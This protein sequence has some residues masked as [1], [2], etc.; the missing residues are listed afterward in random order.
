MLFF[1][2]QFALLGISDFK[3]ATVRQKGVWKSVTT[4]YGELFVMIYG[5]QLMLKWFAESLALLH[6]VCSEL[7]IGTHIL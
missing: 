3:E 5:T 7:I 6:L 4:V 2:G 1:F